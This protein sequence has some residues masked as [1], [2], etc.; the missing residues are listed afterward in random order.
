[1]KKPFPIATAAALFASFAALP[2][3]HAQEKVGPR[4]DF[5][6][7][8]GDHV[9]FYG[10]SITEQRLY[11]SDIENFVLTRYPT[12]HVDFYQSGVGGDKVSGGK[13]GPIDLRLHRDVF[14]HTPT[15]VTIMLG[16]NDGY[17]RQYDPDIFT[18]YSNG[19]RYIVDAIQ[20]EFP[21]AK[22]TLAE[23]SAYDDVTRAASMPGGY[24]ATLVKFSK[25][26]ADLAAEKNTGIAD[27]NTP[28]VDTLKKAKAEDSGLAPTL[29]ND[30]MHP[31]PAIHWVMAEAVLKA[32]NAAPQVTSVNL[33]VEHERI[34]VSDNTEATDLTV[35]PNGITWNQ[36]DKALPLPL[37]PIDADPAMQLVIRSS[38]L[39]SSLDQETLAV[40]GLEA[41]TYQLKIDDRV[42]GSFSAEKLAK[43]INLAL[44]ETPM[45]E[46]SRRVA[47]DTDLVNQYD[48][49]WFTTNALPPDEIVADTLKSLEDARDKAIDRQHRD[50][51]PLPHHFQ[52][53]ETSTPTQPRPQH[54]KPTKK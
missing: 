43:G 10:D 29:I 32:W 15:V 8:D 11:T 17:V 54:R 27:L 19:Y 23:P 25:F 12:L 33:S 2:A 26:V 53:I 20:K 50:A 13:Y 6:I 7:A 34:E 24:N 35:L 9:V 31:G 4:A 46:Q 21:K 28:V 42:G 45:L 52:L 39:I 44:L 30:R 36:Q 18:T 41:G 38:D 16:M 48:A 40:T 37:G 47:R 22:I 1:M 14:D 51:M 49:A 3:A 5:A